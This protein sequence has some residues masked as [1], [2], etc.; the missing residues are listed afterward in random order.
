LSKFSAITVLGPAAVPLRVG[1]ERGAVDDR[2]VGLERVEIVAVGA[3]QQ[4]A[5]EEA[6]PG[7]LRHH[8]HVEPVRRVGAGE[9]SC[10]K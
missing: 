10:T 8:P 1:A 4:V 5:D 2:E 3:A 9:R 6:V 7:E